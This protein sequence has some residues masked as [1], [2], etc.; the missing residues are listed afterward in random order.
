MFKKQPLPTDLIGDKTV[1]S[2]ERIDF[3]GEVDELSAMIMEYTHFEKDEK[4]VLQLRK[5]VNILS[6]A[7]AE[8]AGG[9]G[10]VGSLHLSEL[11]ELVESYNQKAGAFNCFVLPGET[12]MGAKLHVLRTVTRRVERA[13]ARVYEKYGGSEIIFEYLNKLSSLFFALARIY[14]EN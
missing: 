6:I 1:K 3:F 5:I 8:T 11:I 13:Y 10:K 9:M 4:L 14:D 7:L 12:L 2:D